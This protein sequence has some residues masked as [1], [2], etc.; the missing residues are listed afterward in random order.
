MRKTLKLITKFMAICVLLVL[1]SCEKDLYEDQIH[2]DNIANKI[3]MVQKPFGELLLNE[4]FNTAYQK[5]TKAKTKAKTVA[6]GKSAL[7]ELYG[8]TIVDAVPSKIITEEGKEGTTYIM[9]IERPLK[10]DLK[11]ENLIMTVTDEKTEAYIMKY[12]LAEKAVKEEFHDAI[13][14]NITNT[15]MTNL[16]LNANTNDGPCLSYYIMMCNDIGANDGTW[17][18]DHEATQFCIE[19]SNDLYLS[20]IT[21]CEQG[22]EIDGIGNGDTGNTGAGSS[23]SPTGSN[24]GGASSPIPSSP[25]P[26]PQ[27]INI[28]KTPCQQLNTLTGLPIANTSPPKTVLTNLNSLANEMTTNP[29]ERMFSLTPTT[30]A[31]NEFVE[32]YLEGPLNG[33][34]VAFSAGYN[35]L[36]V[37]M[38]CH[39]LTSQYSIF[40]LQ[41]LQEIS[42]Y[43]DTGNIVNPETFTSIVVT[44]QGTKYAIKIIPQSSELGNDNYLAN[45]FAG[46][47]FDNI[48]KEREKIYES[49]V[50]EAQTPAQNELGFLKFIKTQKFGFELYKADATFSQWT[51]LSLA[52]NGQVI[53]TP[54]SN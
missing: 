26:G 52:T 25:I 19:H 23:G 1:S 27:N 34:E 17:H 8:F 12:T 49:D 9:L 22:G 6:Q 51:K 15:E 5:V 39:Y 37:I 46:W 38:H 35:V 10:E 20:L 18:H 24:S 33:N 50:T 47:D 29:R 16:K 4:R 14:M 53:Q 54:C 3:K 28:K 21:V 44:A 11:F 13:A 42:N 2:K 36:S 41:D 40:S 48:K 43:I 45:F 32:N 30:S 31:E 7:E